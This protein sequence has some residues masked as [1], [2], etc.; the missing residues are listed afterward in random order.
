MAREKGIFL[1]F[2]IL[3]CYNPINWG[4]CNLSYYFQTWEV[5]DSEE[6]K[7]EGRKQ[8]TEKSDF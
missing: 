3:F 5:A 7:T 8:K 4:C 2:Y 6:Q 1:A